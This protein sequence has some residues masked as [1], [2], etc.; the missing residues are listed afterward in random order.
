MRTWTDEKTVVNLV[1]LSVE[2]SYKC[3]IKYEHFR[4]AHTTS[5][6]HDIWFIINHEVPG[7]GIDPLHWALS[8][9]EDKPANDKE[10]DGFPASFDPC[11]FN[12]CYTVRVKMT[13]GL[14]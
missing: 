4:H 3:F 14:F 8:L 9:R 12:G 10:T 7:P 1:I 11:L 13:P 2:N 6:R 5:F